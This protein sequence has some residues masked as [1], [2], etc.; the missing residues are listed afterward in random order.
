MLADILKTIDEI[1][2]RE[3]TLVDKSFSEYR[4]SVN[5]DGKNIPVLE[6]RMEKIQSM[7]I[8]LEEIEGRLLE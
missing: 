4:M 5:I 8:Q 1:F 7:L 6:Q 3:L 2:N